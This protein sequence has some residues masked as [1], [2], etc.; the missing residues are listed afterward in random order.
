[1][2][3]RCESHPAQAL[4]N[5]Q[6]EAFRVRG[7]SLIR[8]GCSHDFPQLGPELERAGFTARRKTQR[9]FRR[10]RQVQSSQHA[11]LAPVRGLRDKPIPKNMMMRQLPFYFV[12]GCADWRPHSAKRHVPAKGSEN[13]QNLTNNTPKKEIRITRVNI[14]L[15]MGGLTFEAAMMVPYGGLPKT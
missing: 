2:H 14:A 4:A 7:E 15:A 6:A 11:L 3:W 8:K 10:R 12:Q 13:L 1:M 5:A 9:D